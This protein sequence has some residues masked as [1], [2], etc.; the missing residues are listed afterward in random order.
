MTF[1]QQCS[2]P[3]LFFSSSPVSHFL[4]PYWFLFF[5]SCSFF[6][7]LHPIFYFISCI[8]PLTFLLP[9]SLA[10]CECASARNNLNQLCLCMHVLSLSFSQPREL[11]DS[12]DPSGEFGSR[13]LLR[14][15]RPCFTKLT[16]F[17]LFNS[18]PGGS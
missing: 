6:L 15:S 9:P 1:F 5:C 18:G 14:A 10:A 2:F 11:K 16:S 4:T 3:S 8:P 7:P 17:S 13:D 12:L